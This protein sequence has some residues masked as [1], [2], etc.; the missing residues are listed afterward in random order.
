GLKCA[1]STTGNVWFVIATSEPITFVPV[2]HTRIENPMSCTAG[3][4]V[5]A[6][7]PGI[8][9]HVARSPT[10]LQR[11]HEYVKTMGVDP[12]HVPAVSDNGVSTTFPPRI[13]G[14]VR[15]RT[16]SAMT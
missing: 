4:Y 9:T 5:L 6:V 1:L 16:A 12:S 2:I 15:S 10:G 8:W 14:V 3:V 7:A 11:R 13:C